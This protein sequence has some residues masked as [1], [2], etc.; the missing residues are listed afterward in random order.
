MKYINEIHHSIKFTF[1]YSYD[2]VNFLDTTVQITSDG[3]LKTD[4]Y[5][6]PTDTHGYLN[7]SS[8]HPEHTKKGIPYGQFMRLCRICS[9]DET[10]K[11]R[12]EEF[13]SYFISCGYSEREINNTVKKF[14][15]IT[16]DNALEPNTSRSEP[17]TPLVIT[18]NPKI[19]SMKE[20]LS[21]HWNITQTT[22]ECRNHLKE[23][24]TLIYRRNK[25][26]KDILVR[27]KFDSKNSNELEIGKSQPCNKAKCTWD[28]NMTNTSTFK[29]TRTSKEFKILHHLNCQSPWVIY[30]VHCTNCNKQYIGKSKTGLNIRLNNHRSHINTKFTACKLTQHYINNPGCKF[31][32]HAKITAIEQ[33]RCYKNDKFTDEMKDEILKRRERYWQNRL[34]TFTPFGINKRE[35]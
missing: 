7:R 4:V 16:Q 18:Y 22:E 12:L 20:S 35:G 9:D 13:K 23:K 28:K 11:K 33:L 3:K 21:K 30:L 34:Q 8:C 32:Q 26:L 31:E 15:N 5:Q 24:P 1:E 2:K 14:N 10:F 27:T 25:N 29:S 6:K 17:T 19:N